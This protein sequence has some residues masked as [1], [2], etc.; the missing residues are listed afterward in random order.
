MAAD[1]KTEKPTAKRRREARDKGRVAKSTDLNG[2][3]VMIAGLVGVLILGG[4]IVNGAGS[5]MAQIFTDIAR[6]ANVTSGAGLHGLLSL[7]ESTVLGAVAPIAG[8]CLVAAVV[9]NVATAG[10]R[11]SPQSL[12]PSFEKLNPMAGAKRIFGPRAGFETLKALV[13]VGLVGGLVALA[14]IPMFAHLQAS[15]GTA[16]GA[17]GALLRSS[18]EGLALR[19]A[20]GYLLIGL[21]DYAWQRRQLEK[22]LKMT[23]QEVRDEMKQADLPAEVRGAIRRRQLQAARARMMAAV[24]RAD[25][26]VTNPTH[27]AV[28]LEYSG[29]VPAPV[30]IAKGQDNVALAIR[31]L[32]A[33][34][35]I[36]IVE[37][38][39]L[40][41]ELFAT[42][43]I[44]QMIPATLYQ[45]VAEVLAFVY[46]LAARR[47][48][49]V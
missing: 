33:E 31:Q 41:R 14:L 25:V 34:H 28:A 43:E 5:A 37:N 39:P 30:V 45:A 47:R 46:R 7:V 35:D 3:V 22:S 27:F 8:L 16:P 29:D 10:L 4:S 13:K 36:P 11:Y 6:P 49:G 1:D 32:A 48:V 12:K 38:K 23:K 18:T 17:L 42:V 44:D 2:A 15:V 9:I 40:A 24:P 19:A 21:V 26:V 20:A